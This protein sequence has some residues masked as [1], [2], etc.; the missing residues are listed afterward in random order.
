MEIRDPGDIVTIAKLRLEE[1]LEPHK[2]TP[3][4]EA[5]AYG[6]M[7]LLLSYRHNLEASRLRDAGNYSYVDVVDDA[8]KEA[9]TRAEGA[10]SALDLVAPLKGLNWIDIMNDSATVTLSNLEALHIAG[11][12]AFMP[13]SSSN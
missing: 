10:A 1:A 5:V 8:S 13:D 3:L 11:P 2:G 12:D 6:A 9:A 4:E 7:N